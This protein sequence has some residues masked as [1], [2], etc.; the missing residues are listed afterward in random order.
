V[1]RRVKVLFLPT[2]TELKEPWE[3]DVIQ[4][5]GPRH[6]LTIYDY[7]APMAPQF[8]GV[9]MVIDFSGHLVSR[10]MADAASSVKLWHLLVTGFDHFDL[11]YWQMKNIPVANC[12]GAFA[13][14]AMAEGAIMFMLMLS[15]QWHE[16]Q[17][18]FTRGD[19]YQPLGFELEN[20]VLLQVGF[21]ATA[22]PLARMA[23]QFS[24]RVH[25]VDVRDISADERQEFGLELVG[26]PQ[27]LDALIPKCDFLSLHLQ[28]NDETRHT[29][30]A[31][32]L[33]LMKPTA[34]LVNLARGALVDER[35]LYLALAQHRIAGAGLDVFSTEPLDPD[36][37]LLK[38]KNVVATPHNSSVTDGTSR[39]RA[40]CVAENVDR[41]ANGLPP[42]YVISN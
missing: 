2:R 42:L 24:M 33:A 11:K 19:F 18:S 23:R 27:D 20:R 25:A 34:F 6:D 30:D 37:P 15:R 38:L 12:P 7:D 14:L 9:E 31:R 13:G 5:V 10:A 39:R 32:R 22:R 1:A 35:A 8:E 40:A 28:L 29:M 41:I 26:K 16:S 21:G 36:D 4:A 3:G 17:A